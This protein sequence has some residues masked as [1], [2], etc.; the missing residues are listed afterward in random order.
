MAVTA[1]T[2][3]APE[4]KSRPTT[5]RLQAIQNDLTARIA[6]G[7]TGICR[8]PRRTGREHIHTSR[9]LTPRRSKTWQTMLLP[10][11]GQLSEVQ[12]TGEQTYHPNAEKPKSNAVE[13]AASTRG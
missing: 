12:S 5:A 8:D 9:P 2:L 13:T 3:A 1:L 11:N 7:H 4:P 10:P 6:R